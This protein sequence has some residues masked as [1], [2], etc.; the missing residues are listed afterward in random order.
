MIIEIGIPEVEDQEVED[1]AADIRPELIELIEVI[2][3]T[4]E[5]VLITEANDT[6]DAMEYRT[7]C[8]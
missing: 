8:S 7:T 4:D 3:V 2:R 1:R 5:T 6:Q